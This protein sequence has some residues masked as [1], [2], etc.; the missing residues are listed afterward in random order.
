MVRVNNEARAWA[1]DV[2]MFTSA[3]K[4]DAADVVFAAWKHAGSE[5]GRVDGSDWWSQ[6]GWGATRL[7][8]GTE[9]RPRGKIA[10]TVAAVR[11]KR[12]GGQHA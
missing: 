5:N 6:A 2:C 1:C 4:R 10:A 8:A 3:P 7:L 9:P 11:T 12:W